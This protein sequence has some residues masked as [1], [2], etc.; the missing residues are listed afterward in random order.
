MSTRPFSSLKNNKKLREIYITLPIILLIL[1]ELF[2]INIR[3]AEP[4][5]TVEEFY[6]PD[7]IVQ[8]LKDDST[9]FRV[10]PLR[11]QRSNDGL[12]HRYGIYNIGGYG[13]NPLRIYQNY[14]GA[15]KSVMFTPSRLLKY[16]KLVDLLNAKYIIDYTLPEDISI[17]PEDIKQQISQILQFFSRYEVAYK[18]EN[19]TIYRNLNACERI[20]FVHNYV[21]EKDEDKMLERISE[22]SFS[23]PDSVFL[24]E[25]PDYD[26]I[27]MKPQYN[28]SI[29][30]FTPNL[31][32]VNVK[33]DIPGIL[34]FSENYHPSW[35]VYVDG[36][37]EKLLRVNYLFRG[38]ELKEGEHNVKMVYNSKAEKIGIFLTTIG[39]L[40]F[41]SG[42]FVK[43]KDENGLKT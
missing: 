29:L 32:E 3:F 16:P 22:S 18:T 33:N 10:F 31:I 35:D 14:I 8:F 26:M 27:N 19:Y 15:G 23:F 38:V 13:P 24:F 6:K 11:Y 17:Y 2:P 7:E 42:F 43:N 1:I 40:S 28:I 12:L 5:E 34:V 36:K 9:L 4:I 41:L 25:K 37:K 30:R 39:Y 20:Y 21:L